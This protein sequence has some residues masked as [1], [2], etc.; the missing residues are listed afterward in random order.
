MENSTDLPIS[1]QFRLVA[2]SWVE[3]QAAASIMEETKSAVLSQITVGII[4]KNI[5]MAYNKA[6]MSAKSSL[7]YKD[8]IVQMVE[9]RKTANLLKAQMEYIR[10]RHSEQQSF[11][12]TARSER[13]L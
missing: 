5:G 6:E 1:E 8:F 2:K 4:S 13:R 3:A 9:L 7:E 10:M 11:E 12:A